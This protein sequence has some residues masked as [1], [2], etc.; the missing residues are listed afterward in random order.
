ME[1]ISHKDLAKLIPLSEP[2]LRTYLCRSEFGLL[3]HIRKDRHMYYGGVS[4]KVIDRLRQ[5]ANIN[6]SGGSSGSKK[7]EDN[8]MASIKRCFIKEVV[9]QP[10]QDLYKITVSIGTKE[11]KI[12]EYYHNG[13]TNIIDFVKDELKRLSRFNKLD[14]RMY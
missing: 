10:V 8:P 3:D 2:T 5:L 1:L 12:F 6:S 7:T 4:Q 14:D 13:S 9:A 11:T